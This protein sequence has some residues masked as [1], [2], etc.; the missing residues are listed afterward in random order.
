MK[1]CFYL[2][3]SSHK[4]IDL[5]NPELGNPGIG[6]TQFMIWQLAYHIN[7]LTSHEVYLLTEETEL[8]MSDVKSIKVKDIIGAVKKAKEINSDIF[9][10]RAIDSEYLYNLIGS[11]ELQSIAW[12]HN[13]SNSKQLKWISQN[14]SIVRYVCVGKEQYDMLRDHTVYSKSTFIYNGLDFSLYNKVDD[15]EKKNI[16]CY[17]GSIVPSKGFHLL[18]QSWPII[19]SKYPNAELHVIGSGRLY[20]SRAGLGQY[21]IAEKSYEELFIK[22]L[23]KE[24]G[25]LKKNVKF[26]G[27]LGGKDKIDAMSK[28]TVGVVNPSGHTETF[29]IGAVEFQALGVPVVTIGKNGFFDTVKNNVTGILFNHQKEMPKVIIELLTN[30]LKNE[31]MGLEG[32]RFVK[33]SFSIEKVVNRWNELFTD[34][35]K[36]IEQKVIFHNDLQ[37]NYKWIIEINRRIK[38]I[39]I[40]SKLPSVI[41]YLWILKKIKSYAKK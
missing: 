12:A 33:E 19:E 31:S 28:A 9:I 35:E 18:A 34:I 27:I 32:E 1:I 13:F 24:D 36:R 6:G 37:N 29:G 20:N 7:K 23:V 21:N 40:F 26:L 8:L 39:K 22:F 10:F 3:L 41:E 25:S 4:N 16:I 30:K 11:L 2:D 5:R 14:K 38:S 15:V 17:I